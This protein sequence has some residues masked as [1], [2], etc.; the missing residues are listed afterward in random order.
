MANETGD[1]ETST[2]GFA[3]RPR[4]TNDTRF[5]RALALIVLATSIAAIVANSA[6]A[7]APM[8]WKSIKDASGVCKI[9]VPG[10]WTLDP[11]TVG[12]ATGRSYEYALISVAYHQPIL[13]PMSAGDLQMFGAATVVENS[14]KRAFFIGKP[15]KPANGRPSLLVYTVMLG[16]TPTCSATV[17]VTADKSTDVEA[18]QMIA[19]VAAK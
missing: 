4:K 9:S 12:R 14:T 10:N 15:S 16:G 2:S 7:Q 17:T 8:G 1:N 5:R 13:K 18:K 19:S 3:M 11:H 6:L